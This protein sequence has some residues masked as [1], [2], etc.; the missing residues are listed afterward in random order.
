[1]RLRPADAIEPVLA[2][3]TAQ[4]VDRAC[5]RRHVGDRVDAAQQDALE[6]VPEPD[7]PVAAL[8]GDELV[9]MGHGVLPGSVVRATVLAPDDNAF[10]RCHGSHAPRREST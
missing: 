2:Q 7:R 5:R 8:Q 10:A 1:M 6:A 3:R 4:P 9:S